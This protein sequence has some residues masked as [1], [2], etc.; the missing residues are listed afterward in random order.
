MN[1]A[2]EMMD[3]FQS[4]YSRGLCRV[5]GERLLAAGVCDIAVCLPVIATGKMTSWAVVGRAWSVMDALKVALPERTDFLMWGSLSITQ[6]CEIH[7][8]V[9]SKSREQLLIDRGFTFHRSEL[10]NCLSETVA[11]VARAITE[12]QLTREE[13]ESLQCWGTSDSEAFLAYLVA[14]SAAAAF[15]FGISYDNPRGAF[16]SAVIATRL[17]P[18]FVA[19]RRLREELNDPSGVPTELRGYA[20]FSCPVAC[21]RSR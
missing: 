11:M 18:N 10:P 17:D 6:D 5:L 8:L 1:D 7:A 19:A 20:E 2:G 12:R 4:A 9:A 21:E 14:W 13:H 15:R 3:S 16:D